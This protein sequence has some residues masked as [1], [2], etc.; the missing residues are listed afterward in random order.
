MKY[1]E[2]LAKHRSHLSVRMKVKVK[3]KLLSRV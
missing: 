3:V 2:I 1:M